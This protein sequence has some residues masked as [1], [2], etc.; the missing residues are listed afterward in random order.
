M[1]GEAVRD[2]RVELPA[3]FRDNCGRR[4]GSEEVSKSPS[5]TERETCAYKSVDTPILHM[6][7]NR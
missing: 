2:D 1:T 3:R 5:N 4:R 7:D 6:F